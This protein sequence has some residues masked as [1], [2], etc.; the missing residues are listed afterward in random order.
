MTFGSQLAF[1]RGEE[2][3]NRLVVSICR[4]LG[5]SCLVLCH[6][7]P[8]NADRRLPSTLVLGG[9][10][11]GRAV[12]PWIRVSGVFPSRTT[13]PRALTL[14]PSWRRQSPACSNQMARCSPVALLFRMRHADRAMNDP[15]RGYR[16]A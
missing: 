14:A 4:E 6:R 3:A 16:L 10:P 11:R 1:S 2:G 9:G 7:V 15:T 5:G 12:R 8:G 13:G